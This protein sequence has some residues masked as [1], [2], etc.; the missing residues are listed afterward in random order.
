MDWGIIHPQAGYVASSQ[1][2]Q[3]CVSGPALEPSSEGHTL[4]DIEDHVW[5]ELRSV[6]VPMLLLTGPRCRFCG[7]WTLTPWTP[8][9]GL[10]SSPR[11]RAQVS[12]HYCCSHSHSGSCLIAASISL[13]HA[14]GTG[15][16]DGPQMEHEPTSASTW[17][18]AQGFSGR[19]VRTVSGANGPSHRGDDRPL[20]CCVCSAG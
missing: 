14:N 6:I 12:A 2:A 9:G 18:R 11:P 13:M 19:V 16:R 20:G 15:G 4:L 1:D 8:P 17:V 10:P 7:H 3:A 5:R